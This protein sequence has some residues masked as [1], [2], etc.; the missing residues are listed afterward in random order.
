MP[1]TKAKSPTVEKAL[2]VQNRH[3]KSNSLSS[4]RPQST[5]WQIILVPV[6]QIAPN[7][8]Q[9]RLSFD[10]FEMQELA[11]S[12]K[13]RGVQQPI[14]IRTTT[15]KSVS[16]DKSGANKAEENGKASTPTTFLPYELVAIP[17]RRKQ[18]SV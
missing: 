18:L 1:P 9:P 3:G 11:Q 8:F 7:P 5:H 10:P 17:S 4:M 6:D 14:I 13:G 2:P 16:N 12:I 15:V